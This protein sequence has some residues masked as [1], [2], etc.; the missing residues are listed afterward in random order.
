MREAVQHAALTTA[1][2]VRLS[3]CLG[4]QRRGGGIGKRA[5][6]R[7]IAARSEVLCLH[8]LVEFRRLST[9]GGISNSRF[10][11]GDVREHAY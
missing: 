9:R 4:C 11:G 3:I 2:A 8:E 5:P 10:L 6:A 7:R 1:L